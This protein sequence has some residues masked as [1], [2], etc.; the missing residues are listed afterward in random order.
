M[1]IESPANAFEAA[2]LIADAAGEGARLEILGGGSKRRWGGGEGRGDVI[3]ST[4]RLSG[5]VDYDPG[6]MILTVRA[7][8]K[9]DEINRLLAANGQMLGFEPPDFGPVFGAPGG[10][11]TI[12]GV[13]AANLSGPRRILAGAARDHFLGFEAVNG[14]GV[15]FKAGGKV[16]KNVTGFD[17]PKLMA[18]S[19][20][21]LGL[22]TTVTLKVMPRPRTTTTLLVHG[23]TL[24]RAIEAMTRA[25]SLP[26]AIAGAAHLPNL[27][28]LRLEGFGPSVEA[29][30]DRL[31]GELAGLTLESLSEPQCRAF[32][33]GVGHLD[34]LAGEGE[35]W[36]ASVVSTAG[37][38]LVENLPG[39]WLIDW[40]GGLVWSREPTAGA[41]PVRAAAPDAPVANPLAVR[42]REAFDPNRVFLARQGLAA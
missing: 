32:W 40:A 24:Q 21:T 37:A 14:Q 3:L 23:M 8:T 1:R 38:G 9:L 29:R 6:E 5:I 34:A 20:G 19:W 33:H 15:V 31:K 2:E 22:L 4:E 30:L 10:T 41:L 16:V 11:S 25:M 36:R 28:A 13:L 39:P 27:T 35:I 42:V 12:G 26:L 18:G 17:L 7:G